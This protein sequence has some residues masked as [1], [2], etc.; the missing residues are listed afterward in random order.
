MLMDLWQGY[1]GFWHSLLPEWIAYL[2][3]L[4]TKIMLIIGPVMVC[5]MYLTYAER[6]IIG[7][8]QI[9]LGPNRVG[10]VGLFQ[11]IA[12]ALKL[13]FKEIIVPSK[14]NKFLFLFAPVLALAP[15]LAVW[16]VI[17]FDAHLVIADIDASLLYVLAL[18][19]VGVYGVLLAGWSSNSKYPL[20][21]T[22][23]ASSAVIS[24][25]IA[26]GFALITVV[27]AA[28][29]LNLSEIVWA[30]QGGF[31]QWY[32]IPLLPMLVV[33]FI[34]GMIET[35]RTPFCVIEGESEIV[36]GVH[37]EY[38]GMAY[39]LLMLAEYAHLIFLSLLTSILFF[40]G[41]LSPFEGVVYLESFFSFVPP[42]FWLIGK[43]LVM[44]FILL[45]TRATFPRYRYDQIMR[46][47][48]KIFIPLTMVWVFLLAFAVKFNL[49]PW[50]N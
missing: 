41:W 2:I 44:I 4:M 16:A 39:A 7:Y 6:K 45:W 10:P 8:M 32:W 43:T 12:D 15:V 37:V 36:G 31:W 17:P 3:V 5:V 13:M 38:S 18:T 40:G 25:E 22:L 49:P 20:L 23:R 34:A 33:F 19:A 26:M 46:L 24:Y 42:L 30:Q 1:T 50:F 11:P 28:G 27:M 21:S 9:R 14:S 48:W 47:G 29:S 35:N